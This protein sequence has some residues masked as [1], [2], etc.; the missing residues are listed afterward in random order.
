[1]KVRSAD[2]GL[3]AR[4]DDSIS[5]Q[6]L[7]RPADPLATTPGDKPE[8]PPIPAAA[9]L[10]CRLEIHPIILAEFIN[11]R[12]D[13][14]I[15]GRVVAMSALETVTLLA[16]GARI[17]EMRYQQPDSQTDGA[18]PARLAITQ[19]FFVLVMSLAGPPP[20]GK[21]AFVI[22]ARGPGGQIHQEHFLASFDGT[23]SPEVKVTSGQVQSPN[24]PWIARPPILLHVEYA[25]VDGSG[26]LNAQGWVI[27]LAPIAAVDFSWASGSLGTAVLGGERM[28]VARAYPGYPNAIKSGFSF[29]C[30]LDGSQPPETILARATSGEGCS[31]SV[32]LPVELVIKPEPVPQPA[33]A[34]TPP[35]PVAEPVRDVRRQIKLQCDQVGLSDD[36]QLVVEGWAVSRVGI[37]AVE[38]LLDGELLGEAELGRS[39][40]DVGLE[41]PTIPLA[42][43]G[44]YFFKQPMTVEAG[45][46]YQVQVVARNG[47]GDA[48]IENHSIR[49]V[50]IPRATPIA[51][52]AATEDNA[53][54]LC[55]LDNPRVHGGVAL[56]PVTGRLT[57]EGWALAPTG[58]KSIEIYIDGRLLGVAKYGMT[59]RDVA[60]AFADRPEALR[61]GYFFTCPTGR[62][63]NGSHLFRLQANANDGR[64]NVIEFRAE[65]R[66]PSESDQNYED[67]AAIRRHLPAVEADVYQDTIRRLGRRPEF[68]CVLRQNGPVDALR[69]R[70]TVTALTSQVYDQWKLLILADQAETAADALRALDDAGLNHQGRISVIA[71]TAQGDR[72]GVEAGDD[73]RLWSFLCPGD[74]LG[75]DALAEIAVA[76]GLYPGAGI[77]YADE[78]RIS[79]ATDAHEPFFKPDWSPDLLLATNYIGRP[80]FVT[81]ELLARAGITPR[82]LLREGE[83]EAILRCTEAAAEIKHLPKLLCRRDPVSLDSEELEQAALARAG[84]RRKVGVTVLP[85]RVAGTYRLTSNAP[86]T[87]KVS[88]I[89]PTCFA[90]DYIKTC[91]QGL[92]KKTGYR[93]FEIICIDN[94]PKEMAEAKK[95]LRKN[96]DKIVEIPTAFNWSHFNNRAAEQATGEYLLFLNDD[97]EII[98]KDW[99]DL[100]LERIV[101]PGV[102]IVGPR[103]LYPDRTVQHAGLFLTSGAGARHSFRYL[104]EL[105]PGYFGLALT[106]RNVIGVTGACLLIRRSLFQSLGGFDE[107]HEIINNDLDFCLRAH[108]SGNRIVYVADAEL[109][110]HELASRAAMEDTYDSESFAK[111]WKGLYASGDP[112][113][114]PRL[115][116]NN[117]DYLPDTEALRPVY[118]GHPLFRRDEIKRILAVKLDH[119]GDLI[120]ALPALRKLKQIFPDAKIYL[121]AGKSAR[122]FIALE[123]SIEEVIEFEFFHARSELGAKD[124][125]DDDFK[126]L[127]TR[128]AVYHFDLA[129]DLRKNLETRDILHCAS[130]RFLAGY[131]QL[132]RF[133]WLNI[134]LELDESPPL[135]P[136]RH[137]V[138]DDLLR[139]VDAIATACDAAPIDLLG[140]TKPRGDALGFLAPKVRKL[141]EGPVVAI[142]PG[143]GLTIKQWPALHFATLIDLLIEKNGVKVVIVGGPDENE[144]GAQVLA[145]VSNRQSV[146]SLVG[147]TLLKDLP[148]LLQACALFV[149]NDS[150]PKHIAA[151]LGIPTVGVHSGIVDPIEWGPLG[152]RTV[153]LQRSMACSPCYLNKAEDCVR[154]LMCLNELFP[155]SVHRYCEM[156][157]AREV[158]DRGKAKGKGRGG[159]PRPP[160][161]LEAPNPHQF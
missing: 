19:H 16:D 51:A 47:F 36:C 136:K 62:T 5:E 138:S 120:T 66:K 105:D 132:G 8:A 98:Q 127:R 20:V 151:A 116:V 17:A 83:F 29:R 58:I 85:G 113:F 154:N 99:L 158:P 117:A 160:R 91:I 88:I 102:G 111:R 63:E 100:L 56:E 155:E 144:L 106:E 50:E 34:P 114:S 101:R 80:W 37:T 52:A 112:F 90:K 31:H 150:G 71:E 135:Q 68:C 76:N 22:E 9:P 153:A 44:G 21:R 1:L 73:P 54:L 11:N 78:D 123:R 134:A 74:E 3:S 87:G 42:R 110:H 77:F 115:K 79:P 70:A 53:D 137:H 94:T 139:L 64:T 75:C 2:P 97:I 24:S 146:V 39:R 40:P 10:H 156:F 108:A 61:S 67:F 38:I 96:A 28:D 30:D 48:A 32:L 26:Q 145:H 109:I 141:F 4:P 104:S 126:A 6:A 128:L 142:H 148:A 131:D 72:L 147:K 121:L 46:E 35:K 33:P 93:N 86:V 119:I 118:A 107:A 18:A 25:S 45:A 59:R 129:V 27:G 15:R 122:E 49:V 140:V 65:V 143:A 69:L 130:A 125:T 43:F 14:N 133:P 149:G 84:K 82:L 81:G 89:I 60:G 95:W 12:C 13:L 161:G 7:E 157:L 55:W 92:R 41:F 103:L 159:G 152:P 124:L 57:V 23:K